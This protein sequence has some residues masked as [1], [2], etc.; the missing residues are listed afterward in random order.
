MTTGWTGGQYSVYRVIFGLYLLIH[1]AMLL[2]WGVELFSDRG[3]LPDGNASPLL[4]LFP[5]VLALNDSAAMVLALLVVA[6]IAALLFTIG[7]FDRIAAVVLWYILACLFGRNPLIANPS[8][9]FIGWLL[10]AHACL[11]PAPYGSWSARGRVDPRGGWHMPRPIFAAAW[12]VMA[13][14]YTY[15]GYTKLISPSWRDGSGMARV[16][17]NPLARPSFVR[18]LALAT[19][20]VLL[21]LAT[22]GALALELL[23]LPLALSRRAR[24]WIWTAMLLM[25]L[26]LMVL[27]DFADLSFGMVILHLFTFDPQWVRRVAPEATDVVFYDGT[28]GLCHR[29]VRFVVAEDASG[30][31]FE[32]APL[33]GERFAATFDGSQQLPDSVVVQTGDGRT[34]VKSEAAIRILSRLGG[35]WRVIAIAFN[36]PPRRIADVLYDVVAKTRYNIFGRQKTACP[37]LPPD[38]RSRFS[39]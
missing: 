9:P 36:I 8:L 23:Y 14:G 26:G 38:L 27:I 4:R 28:C 12:L 13:A 34:L 11:P 7:L 3:L 15:S 1:F 6:T 29:A 30:T 33:H 39:A 18:D 24:P 22:W 17:A 21:K 32:L 5:N 25:H 35:M 2:P 31:A 16:L 20:E 10:L 19:P 37:I